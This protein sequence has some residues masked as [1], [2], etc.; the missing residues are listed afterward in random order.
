MLNTPLNKIK[1]IFFLIYL[2][3]SFSLYF[4]LNNH[5][6]KEADKLIKES[7]LMTSAI[8]KY[9]SEYQK[10][11]IYK[12]IKEGKLS[13]EYFDPAL[14][15]STYAVAHI[16][17][18]FKNSKIDH[19]DDIYEQ[20]DYR[21]AS[22]NPTNPKNKANAFESSILKRFNQSGIKS[23]S[24]TVE[25]NGEKS[26]FYAFGFKK[27]TQEC[28]QCHGKPEDAPKKMLAIYGDNGFHEKVGEIRAINAVYAPLDSTGGTMQFY[29]TL[30]LLSLFI[31]IFIYFTLRYFFI[32][33]TYKD[34]L[35]AKQSRFAA[36]G[37]MIS[38]IAH[39]WRQPLTGMGMSINNLL[40]DI[41]IGDTDDKRSKETLELV[42]KQITYLSSTIDDFKN[43]FKPNS[44][45]EKVNIKTLVHESCM[46]ID[47][48]IK[49][50]GIDIKVDIPEHLHIITKKNDVT[51]I[52]LNLVKNAMD[53]YKEK[54][55]DKNS[56]EISV[57][58]FSG[59]VEIIVKDYAGGI[60][61]EIIEKIFDPYFS[62]KNK[63]NGTGLGLYMS[64]MIVEDHLQGELSVKTEELST[65]FRIKLRKKV[66]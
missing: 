59:F 1:L 22:D 47:S 24:A 32:Q 62:T 12:L 42:N 54:K 27:N 26:L 28:L 5:N 36:L 3:T 25:H 65:E 6:H 52:L 2:F 56:V 60:P 7:L 55:T 51:Q 53:A 39:Q 21:F 66:K 64:K 9:V 30:N 57:N 17:D 44:T 19:E 49:N 10:P 34:E 23:Y 33:L 29:M 46:I 38:M 48:S 35:L 37:E 41:D 14:M 40:L 20:L 31:Y 4:I 58:E 15:S 63:K 11:A 13:K 8:Q 50:Q 45:Q 18:N 61:K 43:F 16:H